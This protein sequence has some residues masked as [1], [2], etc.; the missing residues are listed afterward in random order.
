MNLSADKKVKYSPIEQKVFAVLSR[1][2]KT[3]T[4][5][6][7]AIYPKRDRPY[8]ARQTVVGALDKLTKKALKNRESFKVMKS[9][10]KGPHP[11][12]F[13]IEK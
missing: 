7:A 1:K 12:H 11:I 3:S 2:Q 13:W 8:Y 4:D 6:T 5:I 10:R 9:K